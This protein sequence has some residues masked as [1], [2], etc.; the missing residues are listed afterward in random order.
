M[1]LFTC[2]TGTGFEFGFNFHFCLWVVFLIG[3][4]WVL[5]VDL[6]FLFEVLLDCM[7]LL[8]LI[9][10][11]IDEKQ[12]YILLNSP[13]KAAGYGLLEYNF[14]LTANFLYVLLK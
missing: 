13:K 8:L 1:L 3:R 6:S 2:K 10:G 9:C 7:R 14:M 4:R 5:G 11:M 12:C